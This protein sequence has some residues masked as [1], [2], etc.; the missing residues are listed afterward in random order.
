MT[1]L[2]TIWRNK[3]DEQVI[4]ATSNLQDYHPAAQAVIRAE[5][6]RRKGETQT[7]GRIG[8][9]PQTSVAEEL[10][11]ASRGRRLFG[12]ILDAVIAVMPALVFIAAVEDPD[13][14][15]IEANLWF[16]IFVVYMLLYLLL[17]DGLPGGQSL[18]KKVLH[19]RVVDRKTRKPCSVWKS[20]IRNSSLIFLGMFDWI[21]IFGHLQRRLG[22]ILVG[23]IVIDTRK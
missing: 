22:D 7:F 6:A 11:L 9:A 12:Q 2:E 8:S 4:A 19:M 14:K 17:S 16:S 3:T 13:M 18:G 21:F 10:G 23:T 1:E 20:L 15:S 5:F